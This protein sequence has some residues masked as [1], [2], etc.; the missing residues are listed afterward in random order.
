[1]NTNSDSILLMCLDEQ[2]KINSSLNYILFYLIL[3][4]VCSIA[5]MYYLGKIL[6]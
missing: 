6:S 2:K 5:N 1:M 4:V 3:L